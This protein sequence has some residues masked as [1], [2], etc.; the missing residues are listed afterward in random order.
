MSA[1]RP[2]GGKP[3]PYADR[4]DRV[5]V[6]LRDGA[7]Y[8]EVAAETGVPK[9]AAIR[10]RRQ[11]AVPYE[12][13]RSPRAEAT[14]RAMQDP[15]RR[16]ATLARLHDPA[17]QGRSLAALHPHLVG[18]SGGQREDYR[19]FRRKRFSVP[20]ALALVRAVPGRGA[21]NAAVTA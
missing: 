6:L 2:R 21:D 4:A 3:S 14:R 7:S 13:R 16:A 19:L 15:G 12:P 20:E 8:A 11:A 1:P 18:L 10:I 17:A 5:L 9:H